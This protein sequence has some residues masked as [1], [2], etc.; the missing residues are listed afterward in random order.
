MSTPSKSAA[1]LGVD[2]HAIHQ[3]LAQLEEELVAQVPE[4]LFVAHILPI[5]ANDEGHTSLEPWE[6]LA[7]S[8]L[9]KIAVHDSHHRVLFVVPPLAVSPNFDRNA[10]ARHSLYEAMEHYRLLAAVHPRSAAKYLD[11]KLSSVIKP[12]S[13][14]YEALMQIDD[15][16]ERYGRPRRIPKAFLEAMLKASAPDAPVD[17]AT[18][19]TP[20]ADPNV[21]DIGD[22]L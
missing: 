20:V 1:I 21:S 11:D 22:D 14:D 10:E 4:D 13:R 5:I 7:G 17:E 15:I 3:Q 12:R 16:L 2:I 8:T 9:N 6:H 18:A 19:D